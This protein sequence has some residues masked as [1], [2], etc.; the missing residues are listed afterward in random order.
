MTF[1]SSKKNEIEKPFG[2]GAVYKRSGSV[3]WDTVELRKK[4]RR[5]THSTVT[6][7]HCTSHVLTNPP[8]LL[9]SRTGTHWHVSALRIWLNLEIEFL[10]I[11]E[12]WDSEIVFTSRIGT[13]SA[14]DCLLRKHSLF[15]WFFM[16][17]FPQVAGAPLRK[18]KFYNITSE[19][20]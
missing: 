18:L 14:G 12:I 17:C 11:R 20:L 9:V 8:P 6:L 2:V 3:E 1:R 15:R 4:P 7:V 5:L 10:S 19:P 16:F 13:P